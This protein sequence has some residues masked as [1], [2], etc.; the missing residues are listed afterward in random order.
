MNKKQVIA[1]LM[2]AV[3]LGS[4][5]WSASSAVRGDGKSQA[6]KEAAEYV[7]RS[8]SAVKWC[9]EGSGAP[10]RRWKWQPPAT[11][12]EVFEAVRKVGPRALPL[13]EEAGAHGSQAARVMARHGEGWGEVG[14]V[15]AASHEAGAPVM[16][17]VLRR[18]T[19][20]A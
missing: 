15:A 6:A 5:L 20:Q 13:V 18:G 3:I 14:S 1:R 9:G 12:S 19:G 2:A 17:T 4:M 10:A 11:A 7:F 8:V 16:V